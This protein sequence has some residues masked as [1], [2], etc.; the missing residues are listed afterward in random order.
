MPPPGYR[1]AAGRAT[2]TQPLVVQAGLQED[3]VEDA[4][5]VSQPVRRRLL[6]EENH[7]PPDGPTDSPHDGDSPAVAQRIGT[8]ESL[9]DSEAS[10]LETQLVEARLSREAAQKDARKKR[11][12]ASGGAVSWVKLSRLYNSQGFFSPRRS[13]FVR[14]HPMVDAGVRLVI[15]AAMLNTWAVGTIFAPGLALGVAPAGGPFP[16]PSSM[17]L[18]DT[19]PLA[20]VRNPQASGIALMAV[21]ALLFG[22]LGFTLLHPRLATP[23]VSL[24]LSASVAQGLATFYD[25]ASDPVDSVVTAAIA[26]ALLLGAAGSAA[27][28][29]SLSELSL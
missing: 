20:A 2:P 14:R 21:S 18:I 1:S 22:A 11:Q 29:V 8:D 9:Q 6:A 25:M 23:V 24:F 3:G 10:R 15:L 19:L 28:Q 12:L 4:S 7:S 16:L 17:W 27:S 5:A 13:R 26:L